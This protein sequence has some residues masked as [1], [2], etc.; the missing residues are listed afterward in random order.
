[1]LRQ[2]LLVD[3][4]KQVI[5]SGVTG[6]ILMNLEGTLLAYAGYDDKNARIVSAIASSVF[7]TFDKQG[8][9]AF[10]E[11]PLEMTTIVCEEGNII[12]K[13]VS[14]VLLCI[15]A[16]SKVPL[17]TLRIKINTLAGYLEE[18]LNQVSCS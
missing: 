1:M 15:Q 18:P 8:R 7:K 14:N 12:V 16:D 11:E 9:A 17:G 5:T 6:T 2:K 10:N 13:K 3:T 4:L